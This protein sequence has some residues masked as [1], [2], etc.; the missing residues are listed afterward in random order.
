VINFKSTGAT[1]T[2]YTYVNLGESSDVTQKQ[3]VSLTGGY[4]TEKLVVE[5]GVAT[6]GN[7]FTTD[8][9]TTVFD[10][11][12]VNFAASNVS[13]TANFFGDYFGT[14]GTY[15]GGSDS[16][17][18]TF[19]G[20]GTDMLFAALTADGDDLFAIDPATDLDFLYVDFGMGNDTLDNQL[21][22][23]L[24]FDHNFINL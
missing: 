1:I 4:S 9:N 13:N 6:A 17:F 15:R 11:V 14:Y 22:D 12:I 10:D 5:G 7:Y 8:V 16:D 20:V 23:P 19:G 21:G 3:S 2:G 18:V 24:P